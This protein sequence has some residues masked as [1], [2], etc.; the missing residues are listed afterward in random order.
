MKDEEYK[1]TIAISDTSVVSNSL[2][3]TELKIKVIYIKS[4]LHLL[5]C[6]YLQLV[7]L[8]MASNYYYHIACHHAFHETNLFLRNFHNVKMASTNGLIFSI[9][10]RKSD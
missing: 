9:S 10:G 5:K 7:I 3:K 8:I 6:I 2:K 1:L 4:I